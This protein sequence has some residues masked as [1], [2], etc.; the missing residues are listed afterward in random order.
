M[1]NLSTS[2]TETTLANMVTFEVDHNLYKGQLLMPFQIT[3]SSR[4]YSRVKLVE[5]YFCRWL[6]KIQMVIT[7]GQ[8]LRC[9]PPDVGPHNELEYWQQQLGR[10]TSIVEFVSSRPF[11]NHLA[12]L[13]Q[14]KSKLVHRWKDIDNQLSSALYVAKDNVRYVGSLFQY[15]DPLYR[16]SPERMED[17]LKSLIGTL[18]NVYVTSRYYNTSGCISSFMV[19]ATNQLTMACRA[20]LTEHDTVPIFEQ[21]SQKFIEKIDVCER[22][23][24]RYR[25]LYNETTTGMAEMPNVSAWNCSPNFIFGVMDNFRRRLQKIKQVIEIK[26]AYEVLQR[27]RISGMDTFE[28]LLNDAHDRM[29]TRPYPMLDH[30]VKTFDRDYLAWNKEVEMAETQMQ[31]FV[32]LTVEPIRS[33]EGKLLVL[34]RFDKLQLDCLCMDRRYLDTFVSFEKELEQLKDTF[35][36]QRAN[37]EIPRYTPPTSGR[38]AW[39][40]SLQARIDMPMD[41]L[42]KKRCVIEHRNAQLSVKFY[43]YLSE[44]FMHTEMQLHKGWYDFVDEVRC[45][46]N[47][48]VLRK[49]LQTNWLEVNFHTSIYQLIREGEALLNAN[50]DIP[51]LTEV[52]V[53]CKDKLMESY[54]TLGSLVRR[55]NELRMSIDMVLLNISRPL[56]RKLELAF[57]PGL[58]TIAWTS[59]HL[60]DYFEDVRAVLDETSDFVKQVSDI[61]NE[62]IEQVFESMIEMDMM[63]IP[64]VPVTAEEFLQINLEHRRSVEKI[65][66]IRSLTAEKASVELI[67]K[68]VA[69]IEI[70]AVNRKGQRQFQLPLAE[71]NDD[72]RRKEELMPIDKFDWMSFEKMFRP[73]A[74]AADTE[75][76]Y[77]CKFIGDYLL[78]RID[79]P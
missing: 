70:S 11:L 5:L 65:M 30:R 36:E 24:T 37:P 39:V 64:L 67:N 56:L 27:I 25:A 22:L 42:K 45:R 47:N 40:R 6:R 16:C 43:N 3:E 58:S 14:S 1:L 49:N 32:K 41:I 62:R 20:F 57:K 54:E 17:Y 33:T 71:Q 74:V 19:K 44:L 53:F 75:R 50:L 35:N 13:V 55:N 31:Q 26:V 79:N 10:Y 73:V 34:K 78:H 63:N 60:D 28:K 2:D 72:N 61:K 69:R 9:D 21:N 7:Q 4:I 66:E 12:C 76:G 29:V 15:W 52:M 23:L 59:E 46:L 38:I 8:Q 77:L 48:R 68:Y 51:F 18:R